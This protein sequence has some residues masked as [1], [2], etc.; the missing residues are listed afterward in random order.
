MIRL[1]SGTEKLSS[2]SGGHEFSEK[3]K[4]LLWWPRISSHHMH[5][6]L[7]AQYFTPNIPTLSGESESFFDGNLPSSSSA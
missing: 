2:N 6:R 4:Y 7:Q 3:L 1:I 5:L